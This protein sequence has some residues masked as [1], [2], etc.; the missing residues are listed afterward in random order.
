MK[1]N[2]EGQENLTKSQTALAGF[3]GPTKWL[4]VSKFL[5]QQKQH[6]TK[7]L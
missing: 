6:T 3:F 4:H 2:L 1:L 5:G 7:P